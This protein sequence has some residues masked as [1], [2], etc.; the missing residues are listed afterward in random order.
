MKRDLRLFIEDILENIDL[1]QD[2]TKKLSL[3]DFKSNKLIIDATIR[4]LEII[5][6]AA[7]NIPDDFRKRYPK[8]PWRDIAGFRDVVTHAYFG[9]IL[10]KVWEVIK[11][12]I[13]DLE[14]KIK[15]ILSDMQQ[16]D[17]TRQKSN[18]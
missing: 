10:E 3:R 4:R 12:D 11:K 2:S 18:K 8:I 13:P 14:K 6:E 7:K 1:I 5:G 15:L 9:V 17:K 16:Q